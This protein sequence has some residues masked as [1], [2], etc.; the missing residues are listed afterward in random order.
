MNF[1][2]G[3]NGREPLDAAKADRIRIGIFR[4][5]SGFVAGCDLEAQVAARSAI[6]AAKPGR[7]GLRPGVFEDEVYEDVF[8]K[9]ELLPVGLESDLGA[10]RDGFDAQSP[11]RLVFFADRGGRKRTD[12][13][14]EKRQ[15]AQE[16]FQ[17]CHWQSPVFAAK[18]ES[19]PPINLAGGCRLS[20][21]V[22]SPSVKAIIQRSANG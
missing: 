17:T 10:I 4:K 22:D 6:I 14:S 3:A 7:E 5:I 20:R 13:Q 2:P 1:S 16:P 21:T 12:K 9:E 11:P 19:A 18:V 8:A 15:G